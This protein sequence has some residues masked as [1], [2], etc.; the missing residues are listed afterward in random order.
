LPEVIHLP[1]HFWGK[2]KVK[3]FKASVTAAVVARVGSC[4]PENESGQIYKGREKYIA[5]P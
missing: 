2:R 1:F 5:N 4:F 3:W